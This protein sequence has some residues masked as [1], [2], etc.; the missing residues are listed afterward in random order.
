MQDWFRSGVE[1]IAKSTEGDRKVA[2]LF[3]HLLHSSVTDQSSVVCQPP[4]P[5]ALVEM[6]LA[7]SRPILLLRM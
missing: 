2:I 4:L 6:H 5:R 7:T 3:H 1:R